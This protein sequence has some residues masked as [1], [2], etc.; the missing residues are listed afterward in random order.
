LGVQS[1]Q[2]RL[3]AVLGRCGEL[4]DLAATL[5][6]L[7][8]AGIERQNLDFIFA[9]PGQ[10]VADWRADL[11]RAVD[12]GVEHISAYALTF[13]EGTRLAGRAAVEVVDEDLFEAMWDATDEVLG[14]QGLCRYEISNFARPGAECRHNLA[15]WYGG[16]YLGCGPAAT[17]FDGTMRWTQ[18]ASLRDWLAGVNPEQDLLSAEERACEILA[19]G[20]RTVAGWQWPDFRAQ[21]GYDAN[22]LRGE[23]LARLIEQG[24]LAPHGNGLAPTR[25]GLLLNDSVISAL[26]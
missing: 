5:E 6:R 22:D 19:F 15:I 26:L 7:Q 9:I 17:S 25:D 8:R 12:L 10:S 4:R 21:T 13:E 11:A 14:S 20:F 24:L 1:F 16:T 2:P 18:P 23:E 3:R